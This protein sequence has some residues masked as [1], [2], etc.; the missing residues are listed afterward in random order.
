MSINNGLESIM[1][2]RGLGRKRLAAASYALR[3]IL[4]S[5]V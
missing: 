3:Q 4:K 5:Y 1:G 2:I